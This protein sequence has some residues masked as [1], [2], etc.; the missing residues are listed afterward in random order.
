MSI[1]TDITQ[2]NEWFKYCIYACRVLLVV[3]WDECDIIQ[4]DDL[5]IWW[6]LRTPDL[7][8]RESLRKARVDMETIDKMKR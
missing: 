3:W 2:W 5:G 8:C 4:Q 7:T 1:I 6:G